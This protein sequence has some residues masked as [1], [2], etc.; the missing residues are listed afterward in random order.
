LL[1]EG[2]GSAQIMTDPEAQKHGTD[3]DP[4]QYMKHLVSVYINS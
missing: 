1:I 3:P 2:S 4:Q